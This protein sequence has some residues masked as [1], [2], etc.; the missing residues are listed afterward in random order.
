MEQPHGAAKG[1][2]SV[3]AP[4]PEPLARGRARA[5][6]WGGAALL[7]APAAPAFSP[8]FGYCL[9]SSLLGISA[10]VE[11]AIT[12]CEPTAIWARW[13]GRVERAKSRG[14]QSST[15]P[16]NPQLGCCTGCGERFLHASAEASQ[17]SPSL[18]ADVLGAACTSLP[19]ML[20]SGAGVVPGLDHKGRP[21]ARGWGFIGALSVLYLRV[22]LRCITLASM[23]PRATPVCVRYGVSAPQDPGPCSGQR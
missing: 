1:T 9:F 10:W 5:G 15:Q 16:G 12:P 3:G 13:D 17:G 18:L 6:I 4:E 14:S 2:G 23:E 19:R 20:S 7:Q 21:C 8:Y 22:V 11:D